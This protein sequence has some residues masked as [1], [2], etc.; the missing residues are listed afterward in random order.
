MALKDEHISDW[1]R[2]SQASPISTRGQMPWP[3]ELMTMQ[4]PKQEELIHMLLPSTHQGLPTGGTMK[5][6]K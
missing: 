2:H 1:Q 4:H 5:K 6:G 3:G